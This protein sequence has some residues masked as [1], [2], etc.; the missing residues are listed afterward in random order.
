MSIDLRG[1]APANLPFQAPTILYLAINQKT[2]K[3][4]G[5]EVPPTL[6]GHADEV[7]A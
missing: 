7:I 2:A 3:A 6:L 5:V 4:L 1:T